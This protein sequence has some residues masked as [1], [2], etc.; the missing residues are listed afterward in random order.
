MPQYIRC[1]R[2]EMT[3][4]NVLLLETNIFIF[5]KLVTAVMFIIHCFI[6]VFSALN[7]HCKDRQ[8]TLENSSVSSR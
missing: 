5:K 8:E 6:T 2:M 1:G 4:L 7:V 3:F